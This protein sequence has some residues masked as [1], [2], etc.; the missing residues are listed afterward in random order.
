MYVVPKADITRP[1]SGNCLRP[2]VHISHT[3]SIPTAGIIP[4]M[5][6]LWTACLASGVNNLQAWFAREQFSDMDSDRVGE[7]FRVKITV[8]VDLPRLPRDFPMARGAR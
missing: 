3:V 8:A 5:A 2:G 6:I 4:G 1:G 7:S